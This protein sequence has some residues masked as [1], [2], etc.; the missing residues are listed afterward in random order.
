MKGRMAMAAVEQNV[1]LGRLP[2]KEAESRS[3]DPRGMAPEL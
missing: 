1:F 3:L 2:Q